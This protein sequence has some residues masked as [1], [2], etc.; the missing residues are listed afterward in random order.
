M[1]ALEPELGLLAALSSVPIGVGVSRVL[2]GME[3][4]AAVLAGHAV[5]VCCASIAH[6][7]TVRGNHA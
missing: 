5:G 2:P 3:G 4:T 6:R 1:T 7:Y